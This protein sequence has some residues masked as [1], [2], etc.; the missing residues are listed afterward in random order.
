MT[1]MKLSRA[2]VEKAIQ[3]V[4]RKNWWHVPPVDSSAY[5]K[6]GK[7]FASTFAE[8][9]YWGR[10]LDE[11]QKVSIASPLIGDES[12]IAKALGIPPQHEGMTLKQIATH[13]VLCRNAALR[14]GFDA[15]LLMSPMCFARFKA[16]GTL[17]RSMELN[18]LHVNENR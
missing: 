9:E 10:P 11:P 6:R 3:H 18:I 1:E 12:T 5:R 4:N 15:I 7:F 14:K 13:D 2:F 16:D 17:P 8:A